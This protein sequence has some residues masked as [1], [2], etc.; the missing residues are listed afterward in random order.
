MLD[1]ALIVTLPPVLLAV[2]SELDEASKRQVACQ[3]GGI[4]VGAGGRVDV[5]SV[6]GQVLRIQS[7]AGRS[8]EFEIISSAGKCQVCTAADGSFEVFRIDS[9]G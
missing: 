4:N 1:E 3:A 9:C 5:Q 2:T 6:G 7:S 8:I